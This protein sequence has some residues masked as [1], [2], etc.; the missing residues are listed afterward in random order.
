[1]LQAIGFVPEGW[2][3]TYL[4]VMAKTFWIA[5]VTSVIA[6]SAAFPVAFFIARQP[7]MRRYAWLSLFILPLCTNTVVRS[8]AWILV[9][10]RESL[11]VRA[12]AA[13]GLVGQGDGIYPGSLAVYLG[14]VSNALPFALLPLYAAVE[15]LDWS[16]VDAAVDLK[17]GRLGVFRHAILPQTA[18]AL[19]VA[20]IFTFVPTLGTYVIS[21]LL[22]AGKYTLVGNVLAQ[23]FGPSNNWPFG[24]AVSMFL[25]VCTVATLLL[26]RRVG[27]GGE[28]L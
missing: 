15:R 23:Q 27:R 22:G 20:L 18:P 13:I 14:L 17:A 5:L 8:Y 6:V 11:I 4:A 26:Y 12:L 28:L 25:I 24:S 16:L 3:S 21:D 7:R 2:D 1:L 19:S 9:L 10:H